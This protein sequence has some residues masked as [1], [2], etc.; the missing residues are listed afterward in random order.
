MIGWWCV[1]NNAEVLE[2]LEQLM[3]RWIRQIEQVLAESEQ[4]RREA[5]DVGPIAELTYWKA[6]L[7]KF[8]T[9]V[10]CVSCCFFH[11]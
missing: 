1:A 2:K 9:W 8:N 3:A 10:D 6:R 4:V 7:A 5:D 11:I